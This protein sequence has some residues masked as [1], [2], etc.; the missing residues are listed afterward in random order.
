MEPRS[1]FSRGAA[2]GA[3][4]WLNPGAQDLAWLSPELPKRF[5]L[6][7]IDE[8]TVARTEQNR[9]QLDDELLGAVFGSPLLLDRPLLDQGPGGRQ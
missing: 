3:S 8:A 7:W 4:S 6:G 1:V 9:Q 2:P 5:E